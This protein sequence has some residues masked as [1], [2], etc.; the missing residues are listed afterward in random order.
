MVGV[1][2][3]VTL[4]EWIYE[5]DD[6]L[7]VVKPGATVIS[8][9]YDSTLIEYFLRMAPQPLAPWQVVFLS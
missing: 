9:R 2:K 6:E 7:R 5:C 1:N 4:N 8:L 3:L